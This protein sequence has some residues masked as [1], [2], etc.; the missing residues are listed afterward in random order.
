MAAWL[1]ELAPTLATTLLVRGTAILL[2]ALLLARLLARASAATRYGVWALAILALAGAPAAMPVLPQWTRTWPVPGAAVQ[3]AVLSLDAENAA[4]NASAAD[5][6]QVAPIEN[7]TQSLETG[8]RESG[9][10]ALAA[11]VI[12]WLF[13]VGGL[14]TRL[15]I[16]A[17]LAAGIVRRGRTIPSAKIADILR[18]MDRP[19]VRIVLSAETPVP[20]V[21]W[22]RQHTIALPAAAESWPH[23]M[24]QSVLLHELAHVERRD[25][26]MHLLTR[27]VVAFYWLNPLVWFGARRLTTERER[28]C[29][30]RALRCKAPQAYAGHLL[31]V[32]ELTRSAPR[33]AALAMAGQRALLERIRSILDPRIDRY[34]VSRRRLLIAG[35]VLAL[36]T[37]TVATLR[38]RRQPAPDPNLFAALEHPDAALRQRA[39]WAFGEFE[40]RAGMR[41]LLNRVGDPDPAVRGTV[42]WALGEIKDRRAVEA[43]IARLERD[44]DVLVREMAAIALGE[45][46][47]PTA[48]SPLVSA[49][50]REPALV[51]AIAWALGEISHTSAPMALR[52][53]RFD[54]PIA[55]R[56]L[57]ENDLPE[58]GWQAGGIEAALTALT[59]GEPVARA[60]AA[61]SLGRIGE[62]RSV[63]PL[64]RS[65][66]DPVVEVRA[67]AIWALD[68]INPTRT[69]W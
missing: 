58:F 17:R 7:T 6:H 47:S 52:Q 61:W 22:F 50:T 69:G 28:A 67:M 39:A 35:M 41:A 25:Y 55:A 57:D 43:V 60:H 63:S 11:A 54:A 12:V 33:S 14:L 66:R 38:I 27:V 9:S 30:D 46:G 44:D 56:W 36:V 15:A 18:G 21:S 59:A 23:E 2:T 16:H 42:V 10:G 26:P 64:L 45:I 40:S 53:V 4:G 34:P 48:V 20:L 51:P 31:Q 49:A 24:L 3:H 62:L 65:M 68:E 29:D 5:R 37:A 32:A 19:S 13:G 8:L 1:A